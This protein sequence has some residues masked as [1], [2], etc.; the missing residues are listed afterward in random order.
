MCRGDRRFTIRREPDKSSPSAHDAKRRHAPGLAGGDQCVWF[1]RRERGAVLFYLACADAAMELPAEELSELR[2]LL[3][4]EEPVLS[5]C[6]KIGRL[7][8]ESNLALLAPEWLM[9]GKS[10][11]L[12]RGK[13]GFGH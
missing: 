1:H 7:H 9:Q 10:R 4:A 5:V 6:A 11:W 8:Y 3:G 2:E 13:L 12:A